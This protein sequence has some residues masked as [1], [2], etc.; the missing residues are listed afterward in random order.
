MICKAS[1]G[2]QVYRMDRDTTVEALRRGI[3][4]GL[5]ESRTPAGTPCLRFTEGTTRHP[6]LRASQL[7]AS[8]P[9]DLGVRRL[10][11]QTAASSTYGA[12][13]SGLAA[14]CDP[15][16]QPAAPRGPTV[17]GVAAPEPPASECTSGLTRR[18]GAGLLVAG[19]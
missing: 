3:D 15:W 8:S 14:E 1:Y 11:N 7:L 13:W 4:E 6:F 10:R 2:G 12:C 5:I 17:V 9:D 19:R 16:L 18:A